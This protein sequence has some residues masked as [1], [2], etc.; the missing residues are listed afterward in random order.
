MMT[1]KKLQTLFT[2]LVTL[3]ALSACSSTPDRYAFWSNDID[4]VHDMEA[5]APNLADI[6]TDRDIDNTKSEFDDLRDR[7]ENDR[8]NAYTNQKDA[9]LDY[10]PTAPVNSY[11]DTYASA[12]SEAIYTP[13]SV[14]IN[15]GAL[16]SAPYVYGSSPAIYSA[17]Y[18]ET[19]PA[20]YGYQ[21]PSY[22]YGAY[23]QEIATL[24]SQNPSV[25]INPLP[26]Y[27]SGGYDMASTAPE[28]GQLLFKHGS[29]RLSTQDK[30][31]IKEL[32]SSLKSD[33]A[34]LRIVGHASTRVEL[35]DPFKS[36]LVNLKMSEKRA[37][38]VY[39]EFQKNGI[40][41]DRLNLTAHGDSVPNLPVQGLNPE[42]ADRRVEILID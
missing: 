31:Y 27:Q 20:N 32:A 13:N 29:S 35:D 2:C 25:T 28:E 26:D 4:N 14:Q 33:F 3:G 30:T 38:A 5:S 39:K 18:Q 24:M 36:R 7:L 37:T 1:F 6:P 23:G 34:P 16:E 11:S 42:A 22:S 41:A 40:S 12:P 15:Y 17:Y 8:D 21:Q 9:Y 19:A 10:Q